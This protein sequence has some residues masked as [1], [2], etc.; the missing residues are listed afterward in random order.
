MVV[1]P[2][3]GRFLVWEEKE[4]CLVVR[5][6]VSVI[7]PTYNRAT[8]LKRALESVIAQ[9]YGELEI[10][11]VDN[12]STDNTTEVVRGFR[13]QRIRY[14]PYTARQNAAAA[15]NAGASIAT[16]A[17]LAFLDSDD[18]WEP[19]HL[20][21]SLKLLRENRHVKGC[22]G[23]FKVVSDHRVRRLPATDYTPS[24]N[25]AEYILGFGG[26]ARTSTFVVDSQAF[27]DVLFDENLEKHQD[28]DFAI[29]F[30]TAYG[31]IW[32]SEPT[33]LIYIDSP[34]RMSRSMRHN[35]TRYFLA[36]HIDKISPTVRSRFL[37]RMAYFTAKIEGYNSAFF[38]YL[39]V[40]IQRPWD[41][42]VIKYLVR[43][44]I[45]L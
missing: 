14:Y 32:R 23:A 31:W 2:V 38:E 24:M 39:A 21:V 9:T 26:D 37:A 30:Q 11:V 34:D 16:G 6:K 29:R 40:A 5:P 43:A 10:I 3:L 35:A 36:K 8:L 19:D 15:R 12:G 45:R 25:M 42:K 1:Q 20:A 17:Y 28:W 4:V 18:K 44:L 41:P 13:D 22:M 33:V 7:I 27:K